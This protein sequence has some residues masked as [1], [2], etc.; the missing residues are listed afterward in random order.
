M[1][2]VAEKVILVQLLGIFKAIEKNL[3]T[4]SEGEKFLLSPRTVRK[5]TELNCN[6]VIIDIINEGCE[7]EDIESLIP[8]KLLENVQNLTVQVENLLM[9]YDIIDDINWTEQ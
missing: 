8:D 4:V 3:I 5:L 7:L 9:T 6:E 1:K 2:K